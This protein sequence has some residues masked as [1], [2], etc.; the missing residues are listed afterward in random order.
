MKE[1]QRDRGAPKMRRERHRFYPGYPLPLGVRLHDDGAQFA[2]FSRNATAV[3]LLFFERP[4][5]IE[6]YETIDLDPVQNRTGDIWHIWVEGVMAGQLYAY[7]VD[8]PYRPAE[9]QRFNRQKLLLDPYAT[10]LS[11][12]SNWDFLK[13]K[14]FDPAAPAGDLSFSAVD[15]ADSAPRCVVT[16]NRFDWGE[17]APPRIPWSETVIYET[18]VRGLTVH[19]SSGVERPGS[20]R[21]LIE[22]IPY[23]KELGVTSVELL[24]A[25]EFNEHE[26]DRLN[27]LTGAPLKNYWG[28]STVSFFAPKASYAGGCDEGDQV[29][30]FKRMVRELHAAGMEVI[31]DIVFN[32]TAEGNQT[33]PTISFRGLDN[34][35]YYMLEQDKRFY[36]N[37][38]GCGNTVNCNHPVVRQFIVD[39]LTYWVIKMHVDGFRFDLASV[40][41]RDENGEIM[42]NPPLLAEISENPILRNTKLIAE[43][44]DAAGAYQVGSFP[45]HR[46]SEWN[47]RYRDDIR[48]FWRG[49]PGLVGVLASRIAGSA[50]IYQK[51][52]KEPL[53]SINFVT[54]HDGFTLNDLVSYNEPHNEANGENNK[55]GTACN[56]SFNYGVE[57]ASDDPAIEAVRLRQIKNFIATLFV[58]RGVPLFLGGDE[59]RR[60]QKGNN[61]AYCQDNELS[62]YDWGLLAKNGGLFRFTKE[63]IA[64]R[65]RNEV[66]NKPTFYTDADI[67]WHAP[68]GGCHAWDYES[69]SLACMVHGSRELYLMFHAGP[70]EKEFVV[71]STPGRKTWR[72]AVDTSRSAPD[73]IC[74]A[75]TEKPLLMRDRFTM[76]GRSFAILVA[77]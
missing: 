48:M 10:A 8:G 55:D 41:G 60:T 20:Y 27:P 39:C 59:F 71:P 35:I 31:L 50:D 32:H 6:P 40:M 54:C 37:Y 22:K 49:D 16:G 52:G 44:W 42:N 14:G 11:S 33:G 36:K 72:Q 45:G 47:G 21:G 4:G 62:W 28:Y 19:P 5:D 2:I 74:E 76:A 43:A 70:D 61:N 23:L 18:H 1:G 13:A 75:G 51:A 9:G 57:G 53:N 12:R 30:E 56:Y 64:L 29:A 69:R 7:R 73:D 68:D 63:M 3:K 65:K 24:P 34:T 17:D 38:S 46:W 67:S 66:L 58:S 15:N 26:P 25:Q 77:R